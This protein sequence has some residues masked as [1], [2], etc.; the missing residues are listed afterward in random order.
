MSGGPRRLPSR[1]SLRYLKLEAKRRLA[2]GEFP[3]LHAAHAAIAWEYGLPSWTALK[4][5]L[6]W[7]QVQ[8][9]SHALAQLR[10]L[11][12]RFQDAGEPA[13]TAPDDDELR[14]HFDAQ[15]LREVPASQL[16]AAI[17]G[18][19]ADLRQ[20]P[21]VIGQTPLSVHLQLGGLEGFA[22]VEADPPY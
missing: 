21:I 13:W 2:A 15:F 12:A 3:S 1:P 7:G 19:V 4:Q 20:E 9:E 18:V 17:T 22:L 8:Q 11:I 16:V 5:Q 10:W 6:S 14:Q